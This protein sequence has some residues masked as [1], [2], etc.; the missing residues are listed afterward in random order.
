MDAADAADQVLLIEDGI[1]Y[2]QSAGTL[3]V[4]IDADADPLAKPRGHDVAAQRRVDPVIDVISRGVLC[5]LFCGNTN[6]TPQALE[7]GKIIVVDLPVDEYGEIGRYA[8]AIWKYAVQ[9]SL[10]RRQVSRGTRPVFLWQDEAQHFVLKTDSM[11]QSTCRSYKVANVLLTQNISNVYATLGGKS[12]EALVDSLFGN[13]NT[14]IF[15]ANGDYSTNE[16]M[17]KVI[18]RSRQF[19]TSSS[20]NYGASDPF[21]VAMGATAPQTSASVNEVFEY[22]VQPSVCTTFRTGGPANRWLVDSIVFSNGSCFHATGKP[23][24]F[25]TFSQK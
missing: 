19:L 14:R 22:E 5:E 7:E 13:L 17:A 20:L 4:G 21:A 23:Y 15:H 1:A 12:S 3:G 10:Q 2:V 25:C 11:F 18:G 6:L 9:V 8:A 24:L 16:W